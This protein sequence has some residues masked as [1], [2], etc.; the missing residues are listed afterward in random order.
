MSVSAFHRAFRNI[1][2]T[3]PLQFIKAMR[4]H[5]AKSLII[6]S[7]QTASEAA[8]E[9]GYESVSQF[10]REFKR[11]FDITPS[12][13]KSSGYLQLIEWPGDRTPPQHRGA[14]V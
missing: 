4:L 6:H 9:V 8:R 1:T 7:N 2:G 13:A 12:Q 11:M 5:K 14:R 3:T 10:S